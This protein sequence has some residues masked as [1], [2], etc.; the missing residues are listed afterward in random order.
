MKW[1]VAWLGGAVFV[2][3]LALLAWWYFWWLGQD[4]AGDGT[5]ALTFDAAI[6][7][8][9]A[10][11]HSVFARESVKRR[12]TIIPPEMLTSFYV[13]V[14]SLLLIAVPVLWKPIGG[15]VQNVSGPGA[16]LLVAVQLLGLWIAARAVSGLDALELAGIRQ[17]IGP[18]SGMPRSRDLQVTGP[19]RIVRHPLY[20]GWVL[21]FFAT[22]HMTI[23]RLAFASLTTIYLAVAVPWEERSLRKSYG[24][25]YGNYAKR[26]RWRIVPF[27]Y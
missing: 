1:L 16:S 26:V 11:H 19:Y 27:L 2:G 20:L 8:I 13:W 12:L 18:P 25:A 14:A 10:G 7:L 3:S 6:V 23:D 24:D 5:R 21:M 17:V 9:F 22:P 15:E 4:L